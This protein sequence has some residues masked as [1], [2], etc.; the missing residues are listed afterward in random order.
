MLR[1]RPG[2]RYRRCKYRPL[3]KLF[4]LGPALSWARAGASWNSELYTPG[5]Y[6]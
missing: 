5:L 6:D 1:W 2:W 3:E 4:G